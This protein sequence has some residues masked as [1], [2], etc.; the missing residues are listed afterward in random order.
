MKTKKKTKLDTGQT[1]QLESNG[2]DMPDE[3]PQA[4]PP[5]T[6]DD[7]LA[8]YH[9]QQSAPPSD[10]AEPGS[11]QL[12]QKD[13]ILEATRISSTDAP[14]ISAMD[15]LQ[16]AKQAGVEPEG[17]DEEFEL[18]KPEELERS[19]AEAA[20]MKADI[21]GQFQSV[22]DL[23]RDLGVNEAEPE[24]EITE[25]SMLKRWDLL[26][27]FHRDRQE[28]DAAAGVSVSQLQ[29]EP[30]TEE[31]KKEVP[32]TVPVSSSEPE[33]ATDETPSTETEEASAASQKVRN[34]FKG[35]TARL[36]K[37]KQESVPESKPVLTMLWDRDADN[38]SAYADPLEEQ[39]VPSEPEAQDSPASDPS[40]NLHSFN[41]KAAI[42]GYFVS[43]W[44][45][46][47]A[48]R[49]KNG[50]AAVDFSSQVHDPEDDRHD[51]P[52]AG[53]AKLYGKQAQHI[54]ARALLATLFSV[55]LLALSFCQ[56]FGLPLIGGI[57]TDVRFLAMF[58]L[59]L[60]LV[61]SLLG[62]D[63]F[64]TGFYNL[65]DGVPGMETL[66]SIS[67]I[68]SAVDALVIFLTRN[69]SYGLPFCAVSSF[70]MV[71]ALWG[72]YLYCLGYRLSF[73]TLAQIQTPMTLSSEHGL[74]EQGSTLLRSYGS[75]EHFV[76]RSEAPD[77]AESSYRLFTPLFLIVS[78]I[79]G[80][81]SAVGHGEIRDFFHCFSACISACA[82]FP[83]F[84]CFAKPF[85]SAA[86]KLRRKGCTI[87]GFTGCREI[88]SGNRIVI[89]DEDIF[90]KGTV[91]VDKVITSSETLAKKLMIYT[92]SL[93]SA[94]DSALT[95]AFDM[96]L[97]RNGH[98]KLT[99]RKF[100]PQE[101]GGFSGIINDEQVLVGPAAFLDLLGIRIPQRLKDQASVFTAINGQLAGAFCLKYHTTTVS[102]E[103]FAALFNS[104]HHPFFAVRDFNVTPRLIHQQFGAN[105]AQFEFP[106]F[107]DRYR[108][109][110]VHAEK[111]AAAVLS[112]NEIGPLADCVSI[113]YQLYAVTRRSVFLSLLGSIVSL[114]VTFVLCW[115]GVFKIISPAVLTTFMLLWLVPTFVFPIRSRR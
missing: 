5:M 88:G 63:I 27:I 8:E 101:G 80:L 99:V 28:K 109:S 91:I 57:G 7:I 29:D 107:A 2:I 72:S 90:P 1:P 100:K 69:V 75:I 56:L 85:A 22:G 87:A 104:N 33:A 38:D 43:F 47:S 115:L 14:V 112:K 82:T 94:S 86:K 20:D 105:P 61:V 73:R 34:R 44:A 42:T 110:S 37:Q 9:R 39:D 31:E 108:I 13:E 4:S 81:L 52:A 114:L 55:L 97:T 59:L 54:R 60:Q 96:L 17:A 11:I 71:F 16:P 111:P 66:V 23:Y 3:S 113:C 84:F 103:A 102:R 79:F 49:D 53:A 62:L 6:V 45:T 50:A 93:L 106:A 64:T 95:P 67:C 24:E 83:A 35:L 65:I 25:K 58:C 46:V 18:P 32:E 40:R 77:L 74:S 15:P 21:V 26:S 51:I 98:A 92:G 89:Q 30:E 78:L 76:Q 10:A 41:L 19:A 68:A 12:D 48:L 36:S 70:S